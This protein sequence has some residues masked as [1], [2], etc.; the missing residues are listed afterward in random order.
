[1][2]EQERVGT[3]DTCS[4]RKSSEND[5]Q[6]QVDEYTTKTTVKPY[7][8]IPGFTSFRDSI[9]HASFSNFSTNFQDAQPVVPFLP[10]LP[11]FKVLL[12][13]IIMGSEHS[14]CPAYVNGNC[15]EGKNC[16]KKHEIPI[17]KVPTLR[18]DGQENI[19][20]PHHN[21]SKH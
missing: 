9:S 20:S 13:A 21:P 10:N 15:Q 19:C 3:S 4:N 5:N 11:I 18:T 17:F 14:V 6:K 2:L 1:M 7:S 8:K 16:T 12:S